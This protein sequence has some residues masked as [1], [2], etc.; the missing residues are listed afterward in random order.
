VQLKSGRRRPRVG[1]VGL[2][3]I[4]LNRMRAIMRDGCVDAVAVADL[5]PEAVAEARL[6]AEDA[7]ACGTLEDALRHQLDGVVIAT[8]SAMHAAQTIA[9]LE[10]GVAVFCQKPLGRTAAEAEAAVDA[11]RKADLLLSVDLSYRHTAAM[12]AIHDMIRAGDIGKIYSVDMTFHNAY[13]PDK[14]WF[15]DKKWSGGGC[16]IDLGVHLVDL[17]LWTLDWPAVENVAGHLFAHGAPV[18]KDGVEDFATASITLADGTLLRLACSW[19]LP[20]GQ[21][22]VIGVDFVGTTGGAS[23]RNVNGSFYDFT[24][25]LHRGTQS[26]LLTQPPDNWDGRAAA[27]WARRLANGEGFDPQAVHLA[28]LSRVIDRIYAAASPAP[29]ISRSPS[30]AMTI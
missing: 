8:P 21:D 23:L 16:L 25:H 13:G 24:G 10:Q 19:N 7:A 3:W 29:Q 30:S 11:A 22:A 1:F 4:G 20:A 27:A 14:A 12:K 9:A 5:S 2:G 26:T 15:H 6:V 28:D 18:T 17:A